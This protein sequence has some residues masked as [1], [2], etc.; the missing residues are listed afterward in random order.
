M[1]IKFFI[2]ASVLLPFVFA[3]FV[4]CKETHGGDISSQVRLASEN[5]RQTLSPELNSRQAELPSSR[6]AFQ[7]TLDEIAELERAGSWFQGLAL[8]ES[9]IRENAGD[10]AGAVAAAYK[11]LAWA[12]GLG[13]IKK[14]EAEQG[15]LNVLAANNDEN[16]AICADAI[17]AFINGKWNDAS[18]GLEYFFNDFDEPD[19]FGRWMILVCAMEKNKSSGID[20][21]RPNE[22]YKAI[23]ARYAQFPEYWH[24]GARAFSGAI[25]AQYAETCINSSPLGPFADECRSILASFTG[26]KTEDG[27][28]I[29]TKKEIESIISQSV[30]LNNP[31]F[32]NSLLPLI[33]LPDNPYTVY[34]VGALRALISYPKFRDYFNSQAAFA[35]GRLAERLSYICRG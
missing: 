11:E 34:A 6:H 3:A 35:K 31:E 7:Q 28:S 24:R 29:K 23:R 21:R 4:S 5:T 27:L 26:L 13:L 32:L 1:N 9:S 10:Y 30:N 20:D 33:G 18:L 14:E 8:T 22:A 2:L 19:G 25:A 17:L 16:V 12:Y 15:L